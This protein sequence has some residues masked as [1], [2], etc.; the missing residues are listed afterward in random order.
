MKH[1]G[2]QLQVLA[3]YRRALRLAREKPG[4]S[5]IS[6]VEFVRKEFRKHKD[7]DKKDFRRIEYLIRKA[8][9]QLALFASPTSSAVTSVSAK[10]Q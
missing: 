6:S 7:V 4:D 8:E 1:S 10:E 9:K 5:R 3:L 2:L